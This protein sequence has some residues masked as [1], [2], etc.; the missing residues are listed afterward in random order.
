MGMMLLPNTQEQLNDM[1]EHCQCYR[2]E[3]CKNCNGKYSFLLNVGKK[4]KKGL[5][6]TALSLANGKREN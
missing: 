2:F 1:S 3:P 6:A 4:R 5:A